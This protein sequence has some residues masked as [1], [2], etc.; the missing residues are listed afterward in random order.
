MYFQNFKV[1]IKE[2]KERRNPK[3]STNNAR[4]KLFEKSIAS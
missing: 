2:S 1:T 4:S 3:A